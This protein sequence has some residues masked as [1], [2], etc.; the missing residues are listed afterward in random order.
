MW[1]P[2]L[3]GCLALGVL[4]CVEPLIICVGPIVAFGHKRV[5]IGY[6]RARFPLAMVV[7]VSRVVPSDSEGS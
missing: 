7:L 2:I 6:Q 3:A 5:R 1:R 4:L